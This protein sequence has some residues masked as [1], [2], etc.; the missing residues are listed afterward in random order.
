MST[1]LVSIIVPTKNNERTIDLLMKSLQRQCVKMEVI[2]VD[3][4]TDRT[5]EIVMK[6][7]FVK[8]I[9]V[10][11]PGANLARN[12]GV[13]AAR[14]DIIV[15]TDGDCEVPSD[16]LRNI[17]LEY[18]RFPDA[19]CIGGSVLVGG[20]L[21]ENV[22]ACYYSESIWPMMPIY[23]R[24]VRLTKNNFHKIRV[25]NTN[26]ISFRREIFNRY[27]FDEEFIG[28]YEEVD[29]LWKICSNDL[30][31]LV[32]PR[33][34]VYHHHGKDLKSLL[35]RAYNYGRGHL[36]FFIKHPRCPLA[37]IPILVVLVL[38]P[39]LL[40]I[41]G[42]SIQY[43]GIVLGMA[44]T[45]CSLLILYAK[46]RYCRKKVLLYPLLDILFYTTFAIGIWIELLKRGFHRIRSLL[47]FE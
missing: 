30:Y 17:L 4:S 35:R 45:Y 16:W 23:K 2:V 24:N 14:G 46:R 6:Y 31:I 42:L 38:L 40:L 47:S 8:L 12:I 25:P 15:F 32:S 36:L 3:F 26:N 34:V 7:D 44:I 21:K 33:I 43:F 41:L 10:R 18:K 39:V 22:I 11:R 29:L 27:S 20:N 9:R 5:P 19:V 1:P 13:S 37:L 28:G